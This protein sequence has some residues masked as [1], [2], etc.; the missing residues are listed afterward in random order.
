MEFL[1]EQYDG[2]LHT[3]LVASTPFTE[4][5]DILHRSK[6][7]GTYFRSG[8]AQGYPLRVCDV[9]IKDYVNQAVL[10][11]LPSCKETTMPP[12]DHVH[13][14][15]NTRADFGLMSELGADGDKHSIRYDGHKDIP[16]P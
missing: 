6:H 16:F 9:T 8:K 11:L 12:V 1:M 5:W 14:E 4:T 15:F 3:R 2:G 7:I 10:A 13:L